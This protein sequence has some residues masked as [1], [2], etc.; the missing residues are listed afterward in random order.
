VASPGSDDGQVLSQA[1][2]EQRLILTF[3]KDFGELAFRSR[4]PA[5]S[6]IDPVPLLGRISRAVGVTTDGRDLDS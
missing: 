1:A 6:G 3:D 2:V 5:G 4:L